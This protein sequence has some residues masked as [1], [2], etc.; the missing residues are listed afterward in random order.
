M[1]GR[2]LKGFEVLKGYPQIRYCRVKP[3]DK[4]PCEKAWQNKHHTAEEIEAWIRTGGNYGVLT[5]VGDLIVIDIDD[6]GIEALMEDLPKTLTIA[7]S[8]GKHFYFFCKDLKNKIILEKDEVH[9]GEI[10]A[11]GQF[12]VAPDSIHPSG[13]IYEIIKE[14]PIAEVTKEQIEL[15]I[16][17]YNSTLEKTQQE[18]IAF[19]DYGDTD[20]NSIPITDVI[21]MNKRRDLGN[22]EIICEN[23]WHGST[24]GG[25]LNINPS[26]NIAKCWRCN[27]GIN[28]AQAIALNEGII[29]N[30]GDKVEGEDFIKVLEVAREKYGL[31]TNY[32]KPEKP[33]LEFQYLTEHLPQF[34]QLKRISNLFGDD[35][36]LHQ[37]ATWYSLVGLALTR[38]IKF[39]SIE[40]DTRVHLIHCLPSGRGKGNL[41]SLNNKIGKALGIKVENP[42]SLHPE[43]L[44]GKIVEKTKWVEKE[45]GTYKRKTA[46]HEVGDRK[47]KSIKDIVY[48]ENLGYFAS[49]LIQIDEGLL[50]VQGKDPKIVETRGYM[51]IA[52]DKLGNNLINKKLVEHDSKTRISYYPPCTIILHYQPE[53]IPPEAVTRGFMRRFITIY[54]TPKTKA[55]DIFRERLKDIMGNENDVNEIAGY[56]NQLKLNGIDPQFEEECVELLGEYTNQLYLLGLCHSKKGFHFTKIQEQPLLEMLIKFAYLL[57]VGNKSNKITKNHIEL[58]FMDLLEMY[59]NNLDYIKEKVLGQLDYGAKWK[60]TNEKEVKALEYL[61]QQGATSLENSQVTIQAFVYKINEL[62]NLTI[63]GNEWKGSQAHKIYRALKDK[64]NINSSQVG[65]DSS[66]VWLDIEP[67]EID[68]KGVRGSK[69]SNLYKSI[70]IRYKDLIKELN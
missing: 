41:K 30:C 54:S 24:N 23:P 10:Q 60:T 68:I 40:T 20:I 26:K 69:G 55:L 33:D 36:I 51:C 9:Y 61:E 31:K 39:K 14:N 59:Y 16:G 19:K 64:G 50:L 65:K 3:N 29:S 34:T 67:E 53:G 70:T 44:I 38:K 62:S 58:A 63:K 52:T 25:N 27:E 37:K 57:A 6:L 8:K 42:V 5:A 7:T 43:Q 12:V 15:A 66:K 28:V 18:D 32:V 13:I 45:N 11:L 49:D 46:D 21:S 47:F 4:V 35:Y 48:Q 1:E 22:G 2:E 56:L 17:D